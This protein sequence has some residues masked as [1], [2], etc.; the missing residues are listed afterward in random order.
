MALMYFSFTCEGKK[1]D[2][3][4]NP[5]VDFITFEDEDGCA[6]LS[7]NF[8]SDFGFDVNEPNRYSARFKG[9]DILQCGSE[10]DEEEEREVTTKDIPIL[11]GMK[12][13]EIGL[14]I[15]DSIDFDIEKIVDFEASLSV[16]DEKTKQISEMVCSSEEVAI[17]RV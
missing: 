15:D 8:E 14:Y 2:E 1:G 13:T 6:S 12:P 3:N 9:V 17:L 10:T 16:F 7:C 11:M 4:Y 5:Q